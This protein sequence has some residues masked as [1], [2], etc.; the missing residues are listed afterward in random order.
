MSNKRVKE[1]LSTF[2][3]NFIIFFLCH[4][5]VRHG[6]FWCMTNNFTGSFFFLSFGRSLSFRSHFLSSVSVVHR[7]NKLMI[8]AC[9]LHSEKSRH[10]TERRKMREVNQF[11]W[12][13]HSARTDKYLQRKL[14]QI[15]TKTISSLENRTTNRHSV[16]MIESNNVQTEIQLRKFS[17]QRKK[18]FFFSYFFFR[19]SVD[20]GFWQTKK[21]M[22][23]LEWTREESERW[24]RAML[25][26]ITE[27][28]DFR[29]SD[30]REN[31]VFSLCNGAALVIKMFSFNYK[32]GLTVCAATLRDT[33]SSH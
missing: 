10:D 26:S 29:R 21:F 32:F 1:S 13:L 5:L 22:F 31:Y 33:S 11:G 9:A 18:L 12:S 30:D 19:S 3:C 28:I 6:S 25:F 2:R 15:A 8:T 16:R 7:T 17:E 4:Q 20:S 24:S 14:G 27:K 23:K